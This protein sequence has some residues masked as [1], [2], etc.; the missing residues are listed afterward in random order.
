M[1][2]RTWSE[3]DLDESSSVQEEGTTVVQAGTEQAPVPSGSP[4]PEGEAHQLEG[5]ALNDVATKEELPTHP[6]WDLLSK[7]GYTLW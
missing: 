5:V 4:T 3:A 7:A 2:K 1:A 6:F